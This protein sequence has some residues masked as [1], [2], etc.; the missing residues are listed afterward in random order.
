MAE[1]NQDSQKNES[2]A[3]PASTPA[4]NSVNANASNPSVGTSAN[5]ASKTVGSGEK[6]SIPSAKKEQC[7]KTPPS[8]F[9]LFMY[10]VVSFFSHIFSKIGIGIFAIGLYLFAIN[11]DYVSITLIVE[12]LLMII[13]AAWNLNI[14]KRR[15][16]V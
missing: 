11:I 7:A 2:G 1:V 16:S 14:I 12:G 15:K 6:V 4:A 13:L 9:K 3:A 8:K 10:G 5:S